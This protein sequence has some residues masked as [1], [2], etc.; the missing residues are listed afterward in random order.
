MCQTGEAEGDLARQTEA[1][2]ANKGT[3]TDTE[4]ERERETESQKRGRRSG[5]I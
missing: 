4:R 2:P 5:S 3:M 1:N